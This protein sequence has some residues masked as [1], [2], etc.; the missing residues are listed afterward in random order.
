MR[1]AASATASMATAVTASMAATSRK[2]ISGRHQRG[3]QY[4]DGNPWSEFWHGTHKPPPSQGPTAIYQN[5]G[6]A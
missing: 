1:V 2:G 6:Q 5:A 4:N 3:R